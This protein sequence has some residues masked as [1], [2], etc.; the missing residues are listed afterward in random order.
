MGKINEEYVLEHFEQLYDKEVPWIDPRDVAFEHSE[1]LLEKN[2]KIYL[3]GVEDFDADEYTIDDMLVE[4]LLATFDQVPVE[5]NVEA[6][7]YLIDQFWCVAAAAR[8]GLV[9]QQLTPESAGPCLETIRTAFNQQTFY[10]P[11][12]LLREFA[13]DLLSWGEDDGE[14]WHLPGNMRVF[15]QDLYHDMELARY[16]TKKAV[17]DLSKF[18]TQAFSG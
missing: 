18:A 7:V 12:H 13:I 15:M 5:R 17:A 6:L 1:R 11:K 2:R 8:G 4:I 9:K 14:K 16:T 3:E 10:F